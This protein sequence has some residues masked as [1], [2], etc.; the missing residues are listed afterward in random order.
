MER[1]EYGQREIGHLT[2][3]DPKLGRAIERIGMLEREVMPDLF[4]ALASCIVAQQVS[5]KAAD[6]IWRKLA[7]RLGKVT[8]E[9]VAATDDEGL[10]ACGLS[11]QKAGY[12]RGVA[13]E[14]LDGSLDLE[15]LRTLPD[16][17]VAER[18]TALRG[19]GNWTVEML[20]IFSLKRPDVVSYGDLGI[21]RGMMR[22]YGLKDLSRERFERY[23]K[24]YSPYGTVASLY[25]WTI[26]ES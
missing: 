19:V 14:V 10:R 12:L 6:A 3:R 17:E 24:R 22:L 9:A 16:G 8:P 23:A 15:G 13:R 11:A 26:A 18:L 21:R 2:K 5:G 20:L 4:E 7:A 1:F 25:L